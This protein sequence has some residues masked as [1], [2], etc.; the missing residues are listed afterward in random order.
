M[1]LHGRGSNPSILV[2]LCIFSSFCSTNALR[3]VSKNISLEPCLSLHVNSIKLWLQHI[4]CYCQGLR[5]IVKR[6]HW[7][8]L[9]QTTTRPIKVTVKLMYSQ[10]SSTVSYKLY[11]ECK[12]GR[13]L[14]QC[15][16][17]VA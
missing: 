12:Y 6:S 1:G 4:L 15:I 9:F 13:L 8:S 5:M 2:Q 17:R 14:G 7:T 11:T 3:V 10:F 16:G